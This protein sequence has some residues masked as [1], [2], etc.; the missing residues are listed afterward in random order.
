MDDKVSQ[1]KKMMNQQKEENLNDPQDLS[2]FS[3]DPIDNNENAS[4]LNETSELQAE[5]D[6]LIVKYEEAMQA[7]ETQR[8]M[9]LRAIADFE[10]IKMRLKKEQD[11]FVRFAN[12]KL[13][14]DLFTVI[15]NLEMSLAHKKEANPLTEGV[16]LTLKQFLQVVEKFGV[17]A[18]GAVGD[19]FDPHVHEAIGTE[20]HDSFESGVI[21]K[22]LRKGYTLNGKLIRASLVM[23]TP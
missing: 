23:V 20:A 15:D 16:E 9:Y 4:G 2:D 13:L 7:S 14:Q 10:N 8:D 11:E 5:Y 17:K 18:V 1:F 19:K 22:V 6:A 12:E 3:S 21:T